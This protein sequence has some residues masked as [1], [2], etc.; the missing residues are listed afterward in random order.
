MRVLF[1]REVFFMMEVDN[2]WTESS[3]PKLTQQKINHQNPIRQSIRAGSRYRILTVHPV[4]I[5]KP[6]ISYLAY[7]TPFP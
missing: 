4:H 2:S 7:K 3:P 5:K 6:S 1:K